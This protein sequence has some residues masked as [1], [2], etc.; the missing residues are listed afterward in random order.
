M[1]IKAPIKL[2]NRRNLNTFFDV[3][4]NNCNFLYTFYALLN[5]LYGFISI[6]V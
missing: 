6:K 2:K 1:K 3:K 4:K 5:G